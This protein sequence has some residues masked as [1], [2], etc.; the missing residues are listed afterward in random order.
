MNWWISYAE[1]T[2]TEDVPGTPAEV[3]GFY[4]DLGNLESVHPLIVSVRTTS[5]RETVDGYV[6]NYRITDRIP[7]WRVS[8][9][10]CYRAQL[11]VP[12]V[13]EVITTARQFPQVRLDG[14]VSFDA[15]DSGTRVTERLRITAPRPLAA[16]AT[17]QAVEAHIAMFAGIRRHFQSSP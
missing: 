1:Q 11:Y 8:L 2:L 3:R 16:V 13:G 17:R 15:I 14:T 10:I 12:H 5:R 9:P 7:L 4:L 6:C